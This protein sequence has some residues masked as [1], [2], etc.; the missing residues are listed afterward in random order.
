MK[1]F[2]ARVFRKITEG[3]AVS[4]ASKSDGLA[5]PAVRNWPPSNLAATNKSLRDLLL[6]ARAA[7]PNSAYG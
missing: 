5:S 3:Q 4:A 1:H 7:R 6:C 2:L